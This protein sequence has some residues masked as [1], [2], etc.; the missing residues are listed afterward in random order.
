MQSEITFHSLLYKHQ[1]FKQKHK[2]LTM[3]IWLILLLMSFAIGEFTPTNSF[4]QPDLQTNGP[5]AN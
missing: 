5:Q 3:A 1:R 4:N 2:L